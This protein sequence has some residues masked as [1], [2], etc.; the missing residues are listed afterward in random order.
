[1]KTFLQT[2]SNICNAINERMGRLVSWLTLGLVFLVCF[3]VISRKYFNEADAWRAEL[4]WHLFALIFLLGAGYAL[5]HSRHVRVDLFYAKYSKRDKAWTNLAGGLLF[6][7]PW[8]ILIIY[9]S[10]DFAYESFSINEISPNPNGLKYRYL[11]KF[12]I[13]IGISLLLIQAI[14][15]ITESISI[16]LDT[17]SNETNPTK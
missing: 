3:N 8:C 11:I 4:E 6:L 2:T 10:L 17:N 1:M 12:A 14:G 5:K 7:V 13:P 9:Y 16:L 15:T